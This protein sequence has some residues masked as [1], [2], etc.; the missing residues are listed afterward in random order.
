MTEEEI[1]ERRKLTERDKTNSMKELVQ[2]ALI[3]FSLYVLRLIL[4]S[5]LRVIVDIIHSFK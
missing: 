5:V 1:Y 3:A 2:F 4:P